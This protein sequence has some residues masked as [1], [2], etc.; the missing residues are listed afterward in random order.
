MQL[1][2]DDEII[3]ACANGTPIPEAADYAGVVHPLV[4]V[5]LGLG[6]AL[7][8]ALSVDDNS[9]FY[10]YDIDAK[11][12][13]NSWPGPLQL[14]ICVGEVQQ[15]RVAS[16]GSYTRDS[17][18]AVGDV[19]LNKWIIVVRVVVASTGKTLQSQTFSGSIPTCDLAYAVSGDPPWDI[20]GSFPDTSTINTYLTS[21]ST[22]AVK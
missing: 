3:S 22:Q 2:P 6:S 15:V 14:V 17:D 8:S 11:W 1:P 16:C 19:T 4:V 13:N 7:S 10:K 5:G 21:V 18:G 12:H 20:Y 9:Y